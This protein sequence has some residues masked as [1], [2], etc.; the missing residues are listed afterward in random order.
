VIR[1]IF[2]E[3]NHPAGRCDRVSVLLHRH[4]HM[5]RMTRRDHHLPEVSVGHDQIAQTT[6]VDV[7]A[8]TGELQ[9]GR[10]DQ[11]LLVTVGLASRGIDQPDRSRRTTCWPLPKA[12]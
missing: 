6:A 4:R 5:T 1:I 2:D 7:A 11:Q 12:T 10:I 3:R 8:L 9:Q